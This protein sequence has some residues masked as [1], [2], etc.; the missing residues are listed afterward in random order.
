MKNKT[1]LWNIAHWLF[2]Y[3]N[4]FFY[5]FEERGIKLNFSALEWL[6][7]AGHPEITIMCLH[8]KE[9]QDDELL[10]QSTVFFTFR[11]IKFYSPYL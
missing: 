6:F 1:L 8:K 4:V 2:I 7:C 9:K 11:I 10:F 3:C 5:L